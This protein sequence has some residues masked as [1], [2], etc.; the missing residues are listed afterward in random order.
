MDDVSL[1]LDMGAEVNATDHHGYTPLFYAAITNN[2]VTA[3]TLIRRGAD[4]TARGTTC[5]R[6][7]L[8]IAAM[9]GSDEV[10]RLLLD[11]VNETTLLCDTDWGT[12][13]GE[14]AVPDQNMRHCIGSF[15]LRHYYNRVY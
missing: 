6:G 7:A 15:Y 9:Y 1:F 11:K 2:T 14:L 4:L 3:D 10:L 12:I 8:H 5:N 13:L